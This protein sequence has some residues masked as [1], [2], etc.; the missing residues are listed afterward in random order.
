MDEEAS[1]AA[2]NFSSVPNRHMEGGYGSCQVPKRKANGSGP[3]HMVG[4]GGPGRGGLRRFG[5]NS[6]VR[7]EALQAAGDFAEKLA[8]LER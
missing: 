5:R 6:P 2:E 8:E 3:M 4:C 1:R 7:L